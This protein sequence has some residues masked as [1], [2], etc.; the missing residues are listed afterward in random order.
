MGADRYGVAL[1]CKNGHVCSDDISMTDTAVKYCPECGE[2][3][4][5]TCPSCGLQ[6]RGCGHYDGVILLSNYHRPSYCINCGNPYPWTEKALE[7]AREI[8]N[9]ANL[10]KLEKDALLNAIRQIACD[11]EDTASAIGV[12]KACAKKAGGALEKI[13]INVASNVATQV[14]IKM[15]TQGI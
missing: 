14:A 7:Q 2:E 8:A 5:S 9:E 12:V 13:L 4:I 11:G 10:S 3:T 1:I 6:I 15:L